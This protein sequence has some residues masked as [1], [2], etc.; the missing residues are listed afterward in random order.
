MYTN[1]TFY[2]KEGRGG[3]GKEGELKCYIQTDRHTYRLSD[4]AG[5][6]R[7]FAPKNDT[8][9]SLVKKQTKTELYKVPNFQ[10]G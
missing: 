9:F 10:M 8:V 4:E 1:A 3:E 6:R 7:A 2:K 5:P